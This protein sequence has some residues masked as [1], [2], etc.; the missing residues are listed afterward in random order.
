MSPTSSRK[1]VPPLACSKRPLRSL[2]APVKA[3]GSWPNSSSSSRFSLKAVQF[4]GTKG[5]FF[6]GLFV[7][8]ARATNSLPVP[9]SPR[10]ST[11]T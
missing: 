6:R 9:V 1:S 4:M 2:S 7:W 8:I 3:C 10:I 5:R 11:G